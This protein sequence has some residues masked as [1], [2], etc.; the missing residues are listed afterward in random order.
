MRKVLLAPPVPRTP[1]LR[2]VVLA[3]LGVPVLVIVI[4]IVI[5]VVVPVIAIIG[6]SI[7]T[8]VA[9]TV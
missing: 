6:P 5:I 7:M 3:T 2:P 9:V 8:I 1:A 4:I